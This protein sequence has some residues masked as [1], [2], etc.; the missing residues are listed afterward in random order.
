MLGRTFNEGDPYHQLLSVIPQ[1]TPNLNHLELGLQAHINIAVYDSITESLSRLRHLRLPPYAC[2]PGFT[3][4]IRSDELE[5]LAF[6][7]EIDTVEQARSLIMWDY[8]RSPIIL[9][10][11]R[12]P[13]LKIVELCCSVERATE[14]FLS[15]IPQERCLEEI[16][17]C[18]P[19]GQFGPAHPSRHQ[20]RELHLAIVRSV[21]EL[22]KVHIRF[23]TD[24]TN[25]EA[26]ASVDLNIGLKDL[27]QAEDLQPFISCEKLQSFRFYHPYPV[28]IN[29]HELKD[30]V[31]HWRSLTEL[32][33][34]PDP[35]LPPD[36]YPLHMKILGWPAL[37]VVARH[38]PMLV[39][40]ELLL[41][42]PRSRGLYSPALLKAIRK[43]LHKLSHL[44]SFD[45]G[46]LCFL[47]LFFRGDRA[48]VWA[49]SSRRLFTTRYIFDD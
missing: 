46:P 10:P 6:G 37:H 26:T 38:N 49:L 35:F 12:F 7:Y 14:F 4:F 9:P 13:G 44:K 32:A 43:S 30:L 41:V 45:V 25:F 17:L 5:T 11:E 24:H 47:P 42:D 1:R 21:P 18:V 16:R 2:L 40:L 36:R 27:V 23:A 48:E 31:S 15:L 8:I 19:A 33:I 29:H 22:R 28:S 20:I 3:M 39:T 34:T